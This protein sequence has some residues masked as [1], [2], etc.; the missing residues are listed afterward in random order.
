MT[1]PS[2]DGAFVYVTVNLTNQSKKVGGLNLTNK[3][4]NEISD[5]VFDLASGEGLKRWNKEITNYIYK[6]NP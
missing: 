1:S 4:F 6:M 3:K 2:E 5:Y